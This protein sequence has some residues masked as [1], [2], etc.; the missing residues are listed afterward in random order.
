MIQEGEIINRVANSPLVSFNLEDYYPQGKRWWL[1]LHEKGGKHHVVVAHHQAAE[2]LDTY[3][4]AAGIEEDRKGPLFRSVNRRTDRLTEKAIDRASV[5]LRIKK[6]AK[7]AGLPEAISPHS[8][9][10][11]GITAYLEN[12][13]ALEI[14]QRIAAHSDPRTTKLY[15]R[16]SDRIDRS[17]IEKIRFEP[18][19]SAYD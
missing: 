15:D 17:E 12:N 10:G 3:I 16:R 6:R 4:E 2:Y 19:V 7:R 8:I 14:A 13:G 18:Q 9:R 11:T 5:F 1:R